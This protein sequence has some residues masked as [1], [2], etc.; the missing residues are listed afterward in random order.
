MRRNLLGIIFVNG[1]PKM[2][3]H[4]GELG[5]DTQGKAIIHSHNYVDPTVKALDISK[6]KTRK[7]SDAKYSFYSSCF[8]YLY[9]VC[10][11]VMKMYIDC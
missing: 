7:F 9:C 3:P 8:I 11:E 1:K 10:L 6:Y 5:T 4:N 2:C